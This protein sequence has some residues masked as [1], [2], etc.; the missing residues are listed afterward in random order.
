MHLRRLRIVAVCA[1][2][3]GGL[4]L[5]A[6]AQATPPAAGPGASAPQ[7]QEAAPKRSRARPKSSEAASK[8]EPSVGQLAGRERQKKCG[9]EW[10]ALGAS[11]KAEAGPK[12]PQ[13]L[14]KCVKRLKEQRA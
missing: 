3:S 6:L 4:S 13:F 12:W 11:A 8:K 1:L 10:R 7:A 2:V 9:A 5:P 14:S